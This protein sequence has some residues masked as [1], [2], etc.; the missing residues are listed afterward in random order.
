MPQGSGRFLGSAERTS[1]DEAGR[2][3]VLGVAAILYLTVLVALSASII[4][5][6]ERQSIQQNC[7]FS[8]RAGCMAETLPASRALSPGAAYH[9]PVV[10]RWPV[11]PR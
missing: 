11:F 5:A 10:V 8:G 3:R 4:R 9:A 2:K 6:L 1:P 7:L